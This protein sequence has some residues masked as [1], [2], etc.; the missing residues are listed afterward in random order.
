M[1]VQINHHGEYANPIS[2]SSNIN[3]WDRNRIKTFRGIER[4]LIITYVMEPHKKRSLG[5]F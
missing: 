3:I 4:H 5:M 1:E 2:P